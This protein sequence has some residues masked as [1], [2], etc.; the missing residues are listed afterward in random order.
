M[1]DY[2][3]YI[4]TFIKHVVTWHKKSSG[5]VNVLKPEHKKS[6]YYRVFENYF[7]YH[8]DLYV[9]PGIRIRGGFRMR[10]F[11]KF[12]RDWD[13]RY[14]RN[15]KNVFFGMGFPAKSHL[16]IRIIAFLRIENAFL[17]HFYIE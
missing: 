16:C 10:F 6:I 4:K 11:P 2:N 13:I 5:K 1:I 8:I 7:Q 14:S 3:H 15:P 12:L 17:S 9:K